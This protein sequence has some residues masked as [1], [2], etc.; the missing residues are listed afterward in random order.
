MLQ[1]HGAVLHH[2]GA[3]LPHYG[4]SYTIA[5]PCYS[6]TVPCYTITVFCC[7]ITVPCYIITV[8]AAPL[9]CC[10]CH[11]GPSST[12][13]VPSLNITVPSF[14]ITV[15]S[16]LSRCHTS[17]SQCC[18]QHPGA[19]LALLQRYWPCYNTTVL[20]YTIVPHLNI[21]GRAATAATSWCHATASSYHATPSW[22][23]AIFY[24]IVY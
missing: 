23:R 13:A 17:T 24:E 20:W 1:R 12:I 21:T 14:T 7:N 3:L 2:Y 16:S 4:P 18:S 6:A 19:L 10:V 9:W 15:P 5:V 11:H 8:L 22:Y